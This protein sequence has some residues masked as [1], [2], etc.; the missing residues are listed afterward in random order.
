MKINGWVTSSLPFEQ[1]FHSLRHSCNKIIFGCQVSFNLRKH[2]RQNEKTA[3]TKSLF[4]TSTQVLTLDGTNF[5][6]LLT[7]AFKDQ[8]LISQVSNTIF[9]NLQN[10]L[11]IYIYIYVNRNFTF[12]MAKNKFFNKLITVL[13]LG[14]NLIVSE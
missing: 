3:F 5:E 8:N 4:I 10:K 6:V 9:L 12:S 7:V 14:I 11:Y 2:E 1:V 13:H